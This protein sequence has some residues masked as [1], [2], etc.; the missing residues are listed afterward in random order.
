MPLMVKVISG[1]KKQKREKRKREDVSQAES[2]VPVR[3]HKGSSLGW[4]FLLITL[5]AQPT[6]V[7]GRDSSVC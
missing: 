7:L 6:A 2:A 3:S 1:E 5:L 4:L